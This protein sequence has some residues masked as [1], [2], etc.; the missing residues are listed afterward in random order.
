[1][2][3]LSRVDRYRYRKALF[4]G[5][6]PSFGLRVLSSKKKLERVMPPRTGRRR[7]QNQDGMQGPTQ[8]PSVGESSTLGVRGGAGNEQFTRTTQEIGRPDRVEPSDPEKAYG[9]ERLKKLGA[10]VFEGSTDPADVENWLNMLEKCFDVMNCPE[11]RKVRLATFLLQKEAEGWWKSILARRSDARALDW[12]TF[13]GI[14]EDKYYPSTYCEAKR[15]EFLG[16]KQGSLSVAE[17]ERKYTELSRYADVIVASESDRCRRFERGLRFEIRTPVTAIAKWTNFSQ[18]V[19]TAL[20]VEQSITE[21][22]SAVELSRGTSAASGFRGREQRRFTPEINISS[23]Q[24]FK[25]RSGGQASRNESITSTVR[26]TPCTSCGRNHRGQCLVGAGVCYQCGQPG[27]FKK[28]CPQ[29]NMTV[30]RDQGVGSQTVE[31]SRVS[32]VPTE[33]TSGARQKVVVGRPRQQGKVYAMTQQEAEDAPDVITGTILICN[34]PADV[35]FDLGATHSFVSSIFL[36]KLNRMLEPLSEGLAIYTLVGDVLLVNEV[37]RNCEVLVEGISLLVD[38]LPLELQRLDVILGMDFLFAHYASMDCHRKEVVFRKPGFAEVVFRGL[39]KGVSRSLIS[40]LKAEKLL[41]KG[42]TAFLAHIVVVQREKLKPEDVPVVKEFLDVFPDDLSG[43]PPDRE[44]EFTIELL[45]GTAPISQASYRMAPSKLK[46]LKMQLQELVD[47]GYIRPS[48][49]PWGAPVLF[50]KKKDGTLRLCIDYKQLNKVTIRNKYPLPRID[51]LFDQL[52]G[53]ALFSKI[54]LR[55]GYHQLKVRE[56]DI[57][58]TAFRTRYGHYEFRVMPFGLTNAPA[59]F[60]DLMNRIFHRYLDQFVIVFIDDI[61]VYS[62]DR[63]SHEEHLRIV[64]QTLREKQL[65]AKFSK[66]EFWLEQVV[67][68]GHVVSAKGVSVDPQKVEEIV[69]WERPISATEVRSFLGLAGYYRHFIED[70]SRLALPLT[71]LTR[72]NV[73]FEWLGLGCVLMQ[74]GNVIAYASRQLKEHE[75]NYPTHDLELA[76][77]VLALKI[78]RHYLFGKKCHIFTDHKSLKYIFDQK[79]LNLRQR[80]WLELIKDYDC[81]IEYHPGK[82]NVVADALSRKSRLPKSALCGIRVALLNEL[83]GSKSVVTT[84][85]SGSLLAQFQVRSSLVTEIVRRQ[86]EDSNLQKKFEKSKKGLEVEFELRID[87]AIVKQ[88]RLCVPNINELKNAILEEAHSSAYAM[89]P[90]STK[91]YRTLKKT[92]WWSGMKQK[93]AE[94]VDRCLICQQVKQVRQRPR[95]FLNPLPVPE[96]KWEHITM[97]FL[98]GLPRT[99]SGHDDIWVIVDRLTKTTRFIPI[100]MT[101]T[102]DQ[103]ARLYVDKIVSQ[104]GVPV[105]IV[106]DRDPRFTSKFWPSLQKAIG[107]GLKFS[108]SFHPQTNG[109]SERTIQTLEDMLRACVLQLKGIWDTHLPLMEFA[110]NNN[111]QSSIGMAPY[112][113]LYGRPCRTP[114]CWNEVGERKLVGPELVQITTNNIKLI[115]ENLRKAQ[116]RQKSYA[117]K[118]RRNLEF[119]VGDQVFLKLSPWRG[120]IRFGRKGKLSP[121]YIGPYQITERVGPAA[122]RLELPIELAR[123]HDVFHVSMLRK[124]IPDP[125]HV[126]QEQPVELKEDLSYVEEPVQIL[127]RKEQVLRNKTIP[128]IKVLWRHHGAEEATWKPEYQMKKRYPILFS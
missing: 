55:S 72:K 70:F 125:S 1:M 89:H 49:S 87:G 15:N 113:A 8:G 78:W 59:V 29:L 12:Q 63:E 27:H 36:T 43:L 50:V 71:A 119:Q 33:G 121:R 100:K 91:M 104:Y 90:C 40:V 122:Y 102:L 108:T 24:D 123:I 58:K 76:A 85:N 39:R 94:Y 97:D 52:R 44:I 53:A 111:Y 45:P 75:C 103:L 74:D 83:R 79:E 67:F 32:V 47:Q 124:Y 128:L 23:R 3:V 22:K 64:L 77:V 69:N 65:Y 19:E 95:G 38:L 118:R 88:G 9:I 66:C 34:V 73:K 42:C 60:M 46:E 4:V 96:W 10:T 21:E 107:T 17:Y 20:R 26:R 28:D 31:Q 81:T 126:L 127:D 120:V 109:Q 18:L 48:V 2:K 35:L 5:F 41:R 68:L 25:N 116:D 37:L 98:F 6:T 51:D 110:Y 112:K 56:S 86:S 16:L 11:E 115:R 62:V 101:S 80:R 99:S 92:Y 61:L 54:D 14:F 30:Q 93:I 13:R 114:V 117:D 82:A 105:S 84:E 7:R 106:S 57:A